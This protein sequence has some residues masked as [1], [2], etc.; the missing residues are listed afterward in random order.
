MSRFIPLIFALPLLGAGLSIVAVRSRRTQR[1]ISLV[2]LALT[3]ALSV[4]ILVDVERNGTAVARLGGWPAS[5]GI[6]FVADR[7]SASLLVVATSV[8]FVV[9][10]FA[11]GQGSRN[12][13]SRMYHPAYLALA[14][15][16]ANAFLAGDLFNLFVAFELMLMASYVLLTLHGNDAQ[17]R[18][19]TTY[20][21]LNVVESMLLLLAVALIFAAT[22]TVNM[23]EIAQRVPGL[24][25]GLEF[26][27]NAL[28][29]VAFGLKAAVFPLFF[30]L[31]DSY[32]AAPSPVTAVFAGLLT[33]I[34]IYA[35]IRTE[36]LMFP[37]G[38]GT[39]LLIVGGV[40]MIVGVLGAI[41]QADM[42]RILSFHIVSQ[43]GYMVAGVG[44]GTAAALAA[45]M[46]FVIHQIPI[47][48]A[49]FLVE[50]LVEQETGTSRLDDVGGMARRSGWMAALFLLPALSLA[51]LP[52]FSGFVGKFGLVAA[53]FS[54]EQ[55]LLVGVALFGS[56]LT[57]VSMV[58]IWT[59]I[60]WGEVMPAPTHTGHGILR[61]R[62]VEAGATFVCVGFGLAIAGWAGPLYDF[63]QRAAAELLDSSSYIQAVLG[64]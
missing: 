54:A 29:L 64:S 55:Y 7:L 41:A 2:T 3:A 12:E 58:K 63:C 31:P 50:G 56:L 39:L 28:L 35:I 26:G 19:G 16:V 62:P 8:L 6:A 45:T 36:T 5:I 48:T 49:L 57:L 46:F 30:W 53:G 61:H 32:P 11:V 25:D 23:A 52:P 44:I 60:F 18:S 20:V 4:A 15:G 10:V 42:K 1:A 51:G 22:G 21:V 59:G 24:P 34:G 40:T 27:L 17:I 13:S 33:K 9:L 38:T 14:A 43:I 47:K 37:G